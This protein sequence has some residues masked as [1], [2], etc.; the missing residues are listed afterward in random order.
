MSKLIG[1]N[2]DGTIYVESSSGDVYGI[3]SA[4]QITDE[5][6]IPFEADI[7][8]VLGDAGFEIEQDWDNETTYI[9]FDNSASKV[10]FF[11][12]AVSIA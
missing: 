12:G 9:E 2:G 7:F 4:T 8:L 5:A 1:D 6:G 11:G 3:S 10:V